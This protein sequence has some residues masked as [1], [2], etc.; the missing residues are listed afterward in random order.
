MKYINKDQVLKKLTL[1]LL[2]FASVS[3]A[4]ASFMMNDL[5]YAILRTIKINGPLIGDD[6]D[7]N[8]IRDD[9]EKEIKERFPNINQQNVYLSWAK[10]YEKVLTLEVNS[11]NS[12]KWWKYYERIYECATGMNIYGY[13][14]SILE[15][16]YNMTWVKHLV[17][18]RS[19]RWDKYNYWMDKTY[20][21]NRVYSDLDN[22]EVVIK[23]NEVCDYKI[24]DQDRT[25]KVAVNR[26]YFGAKQVN[27]YRNLKNFE[28]KNGIEYRNLYE[29][30]F[31]K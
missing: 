31:H 3:N 16:G 4:S 15:D 1:T 12:K 21:D 22:V 11:E 20:Q 6:V 18:N 2:L 26:F 7:K 9:V 24:V 30:K 10:H 5:Y 13:G 17:Y 29:D 25:I 23:M 19:N 14:I 8:G 27:I 28:K